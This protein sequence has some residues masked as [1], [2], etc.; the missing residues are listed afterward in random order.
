VARLAAARCKARARVRDEEVGRGTRRAP[1]A[2][3]EE[4]RGKVRL[5]PYWTMSPIG[6]D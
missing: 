3:A 2:E 5:I 1:G 4:R 6:L